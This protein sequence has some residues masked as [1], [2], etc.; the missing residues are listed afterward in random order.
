MKLE[1][2]NLEVLLKFGSLE[3]VCVDDG[4]KATEI[5]TVPIRQTW[6]YVHALSH[7]YFVESL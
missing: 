4:Q 7:V 1:T 2:V 3:T 5:V 6:N